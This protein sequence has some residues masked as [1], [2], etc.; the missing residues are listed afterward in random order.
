LAKPLLGIGRDYHEEKHRSLDSYEEN[1]FADGKPVFYFFR[2][3]G[4]PSRMDSPVPSQVFLFFV[5]KIDFLTADQIEIA[6]E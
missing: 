5:Y 2:E 4:E 1:Y 6:S 3:K